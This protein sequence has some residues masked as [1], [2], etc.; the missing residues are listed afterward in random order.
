[1]NDFE[2]GIR[3]LVKEEIQEARINSD[4]NVLAK[5]D[6]K[7]LIKKYAMQNYFNMTESAEYLGISTTT[8][9][10]MRKKYK[11]KS[12]VI[13]NIRLWRKKDLEDFVNKNGVEGYL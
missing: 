6:A 12:V 1:M 13:D 10:R 7:K 9:W 11:I 3:N 5:S 2:K 8:F 4:D